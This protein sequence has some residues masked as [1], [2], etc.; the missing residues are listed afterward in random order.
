[1]PHTLECNTLAIKSG[2]RRYMVFCGCCGFNFIM[3]LCS[4]AS[5]LGK[6]RLL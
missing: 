1:M 4:T 6:V 5:E 2:D 3:C